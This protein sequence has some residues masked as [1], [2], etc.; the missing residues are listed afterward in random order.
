MRSLMP[1]RA[2]ADPKTDLGTPSFRAA[3]RTLLRHRAMGGIARL[4]LFQ[5]AKRIHGV[6]VVRDEI[7]SGVA[8]TPSRAP[9]Q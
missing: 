5:S 1:C 9:R 4:L 6:A 2:G 3:Q 7:L 8:M